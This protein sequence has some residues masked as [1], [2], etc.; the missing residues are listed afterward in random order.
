MSGPKRTRTRRANV[1]VDETTYLPGILAKLKELTKHEVHI[2]VQGDAELAM[3]AGIHEY[4]SIKAG[5]PARSFIGTGR[6]KSATA[7]SKLVKAG[8]KNIVMG[9][10]RTEALLQ[11]IGQT[12]KARVLKHFDRIRTPPLAPIYARHKGSNKIL[13]EERKL[14]DAMTFVVVKSRR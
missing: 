13:V 2:G 10:E 11:M 8:V 6:R 1:E 14:R 4:G 7:I 12:G 9:N 5:I 3:I